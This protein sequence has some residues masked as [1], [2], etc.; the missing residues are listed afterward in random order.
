MNMSLKPV[1]AP[2]RGRLREHYEPA[3]H[4]STIEIGIGSKSE[5][6]QEQYRIVRAKVLADSSKSCVILVTSASVG[7]GK[8]TTAA[9]FAYTLSLTKDTQVLLFLAHTEARGS[10][11]ESAFGMVDVLNQTCTL[12]E[13]L[14]AVQGAPNLMVLTA[15]C[16]SAQISDLAPPADWALFVAGVRQRFAHIVIDAPHYGAASSYYALQSI[17]DG[18]VVVVRPEHTSRADLREALRCIPRPKLL[19]IVVNAYKNWLFWRRS[20]PKHGVPNS[21]EKK[22]T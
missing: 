17:A 5:Y 3:L 18:I 2:E 7:D 12:D 6:V 9:Q 15:G 19:G 21:T 4:V 16:N 10:S 14:Q 20:E 13:A 22:S 1:M 8:S 11:D